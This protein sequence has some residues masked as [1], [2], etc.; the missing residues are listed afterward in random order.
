VATGL[1]SLEAYHAQVNG[2]KGACYKGYK[3]TEE[4]MAALSS[5]ENKIEVNKAP[6]QP[7]ALKDVIILVQAIIFL[8]LISI[9]FCKL[10]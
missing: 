9:I 1:F 7:M 10:N 2:F 4:A 3:S 8:L 5:D 6:A